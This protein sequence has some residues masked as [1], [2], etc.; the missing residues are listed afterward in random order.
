MDGHIGTTD[1][2]NEEESIEVKKKIIQQ[3]MESE[4]TPQSIIDQ[5]MEKIIEKG[6]S[7]V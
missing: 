5:I 4:D 1:K 3:E 7:F 2:Q 6:S